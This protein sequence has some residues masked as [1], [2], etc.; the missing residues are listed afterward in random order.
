MQKEHSLEQGENKASLK[1]IEQ[2]LH[3]L[4]IEDAVLFDHAP[5][6]RIQ[7]PEAQFAHALQIREVLVERIK[8]L[9]YRFVALDLDE[10]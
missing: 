3:E 6:L 9:G 2:I 1:E 10:L 5:V 8:P 7:I 4:Q